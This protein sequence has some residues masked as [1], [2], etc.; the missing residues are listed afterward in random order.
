AVA[1]SACSGVATPAARRLRM[2]A[3]TTLP[4]ASEAAAL[5]VRRWYCRSSGAPAILSDP[6]KLRGRSLPS[7]PKRGRGEQGGIRRRETVRFG[8]V[9]QAGGGQQGSRVEVVGEDVIDRF[10]TG[11][12][13]KIRLQ[14]PRVEEAQ[15][16]VE[17]G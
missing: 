15:V 13:R 9:F 17:G 4:F 3:R 5:A 6:F 16:Q 11:Q 8:R 7:P 2:A 1:A 12:R 14:P 10:V